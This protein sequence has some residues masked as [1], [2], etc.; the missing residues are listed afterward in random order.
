MTQNAALKSYFARTSAWPA[1]SSQEEFELAVRVRTHADLEAARR[2]VLSNLRFV[3]KVAFEFGSYGLDPLDLIQE[4]NMG[5]MKAVEKFD[6]H[7]GNRLISYAIW[8][9]RA[10]IMKYIITNWSLVKIGTTEAQK[11]LF[12]KIGKI[13][14][15]LKPEHGDPGSAYKTVARELNVPEKD[16]AEIEQRMST[17]DTSLDSVR[18]DDMDSTLVDSVPD[19]RMNQEELLA[20]M[21]EATF[22]K[23]RVREAI[24]H[25]SRKQRVVVEKRVLAE[26]RIPLREIGKKLNLSGERVRQIEQEALSDL[27]GL[28]NEGPSLPSWTA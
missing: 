5:L 10:Y 4:G 26:E 11:K 2:L 1:L 24:N 18:R 13:R 20:E 27:K 3:V 28:L 14:A 21:E 9:I 8:W 25:L 23:N 7:R 16:V 6:P 15:M 12:Y 19:E 17:R 22:L